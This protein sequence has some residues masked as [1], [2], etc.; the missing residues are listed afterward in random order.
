MAPELFMRYYGVESDQVSIAAPCKGLL[1]NAM[2]SCCTTS[3]E[4][5][6]IYGD[7]MFAGC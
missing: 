6:P 5:T 4:Y 7:M 2:R 3:V 1:C